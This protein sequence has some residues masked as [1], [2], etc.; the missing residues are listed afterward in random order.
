MESTTEKSE[1]YENNFIEIVSHDLQDYLDENFE[2]VFNNV[3]EQL[4][5]I[6]YSRYSEEK[7]R[8]ED[9]TY[10]GKLEDHDENSG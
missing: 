5:V 2:Q 8:P 6:N 10:I 1:N 7:E 9:A 4:P 3:Y